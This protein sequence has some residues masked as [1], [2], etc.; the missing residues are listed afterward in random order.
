MACQLEIRKIKVLDAQL[1]AG[2][3]KILPQATSRAWFALG[4]LFCFGKCKVNLGKT[5]CSLNTIKYPQICPER[6]QERPCWE[7]TCLL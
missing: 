7:F 1:S 2:H 5:K 4:V 3:I 6:G